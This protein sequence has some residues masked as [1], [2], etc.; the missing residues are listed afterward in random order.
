LVTESKWPGGH[1]SS[2]ASTA[3]SSA[4]GSGRVAVCVDLAPLEQG[5]AA[6]AHGF[7]QL[8]LQIGGAF[9][10]QLLQGFGQTPGS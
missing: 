7:R 9:A 8:H 10:P 2:V 4:L 6:N 1:L 5:P 3:A